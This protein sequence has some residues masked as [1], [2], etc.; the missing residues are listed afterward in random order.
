MIICICVGIIGV[1][2]GQLSGYF[3][4]CYKVAEKTIGR[5]RVDRSEPDEPPALF[6]E[7]NTTPESIIDKPYVV[8]SVEA[9]DFLP[10]D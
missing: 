10:H 3:F 6:L 5:L 7:L 8:L 9:K 4:C 1:L 2:I